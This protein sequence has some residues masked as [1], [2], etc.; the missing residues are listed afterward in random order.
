[1]EIL[2]SIVIS[3]LVQL[4]KVSIKR[5]GFELTKKLLAGSIFIGCMVGAYLYT[6]GILTLEFVR[7]F[8]NLLLLAVGWYEVVYKAILVPVFN[9]LINLIKK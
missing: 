5:I 7:S 8:V 2:I 1:M 9:K 3:S 6:N 4:A